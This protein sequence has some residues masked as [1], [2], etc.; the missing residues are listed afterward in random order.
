MKVTIEQ[1][2]KLLKGDQSFSQLG[3]ALMLTRLRTLYVKQPSESTLK[4]CMGEINMY[5]EK[6]PVIMNADYAIIAKM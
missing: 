6:Y 2:E 4:S 3:F 5:L 1:T